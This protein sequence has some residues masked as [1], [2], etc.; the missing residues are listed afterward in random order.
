MPRRPVRP[1]QN[2]NPKSRD[3][4]GRG[5]GG[6]SY[7]LDLHGFDVLG[8]VDAT[9]LV[10]RDAY[11]NGYDA[12]EVLHGAADVI[13][14]VGAGEGRG[15]IKF[16]LRRM[17]DQGEFNAYVASAEK[18]EGRLVLRLKRNPQPRSEQWSSLPPRRY[19]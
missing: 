8:A 2:P 13:D 1:W 19:G 18:G 15:A 4:G 16:K 5:R 3:G 14:P 11:A 9:R 10:V 7:S 17:Y 12:V 6:R